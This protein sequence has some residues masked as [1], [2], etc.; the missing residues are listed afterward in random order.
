MLVGRLL[1]KG[2][3]S[4]GELDERES[5]I[6]A[7]LFQV[8][9]STHKGIGWGELWKLE[10]IQKKMARQTYSKRLKSL[11]ERGLVEREVFNS[12]RGK[13]T[14]YRIN[15]KLSAEL[16]EFS[17]VSPEKEKV[18]IEKFAEDAEALDTEHYVEAMMEL[19]LLHMYLWPI[20]LTVLKSEGARWLFFE[21]NYQLFE[22]IL[23]YIQSRAWKN[24]AEKERA[25]NKMFEF[26]EPFAHR[27][28]GKRFGL[29]DL[30]DMKQRIIEASVSTAEG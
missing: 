23:A 30:Y 9:I 27:P 24:N 6:L 21:A 11:L 14:R 5:T 12:R 4:L 20:A 17:I 7:A 19:A 1:K 15:P 18:I 10:T 28:I 8:Q 3:R 25:L 16:E 29:D 13:P 22:K 26:L 2:I